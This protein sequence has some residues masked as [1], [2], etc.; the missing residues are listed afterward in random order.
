[1][2]TYPGREKLARDLGL[3]SHSTSTAP[4]L[5]DILRRSRHTP[6][7]PPSSAIKQL[8]FPESETLTS[9]R[10]LAQETDRTTPIIN[11]I[12]PLDVPSENRKVYDDPQLPPLHSGKLGYSRENDTTLLNSHTLQPVSNPAPLNTN[13]NSNLRLSSLKINSS[14][15]D[16][17]L[18]HPQSMSKNG[19]RSDKPGGLDVSDISVGT[20]HAQGVHA[21]LGETFANDS[22]LDMDKV[23]NS[24]ED[25]DKLANLAKVTADTHTVE[26]RRDELD[27]FF[28]T[29]F[30]SHEVKGEP[31]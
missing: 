19:T 7:P 1:M 11:S 21:E 5:V 30:P 12:H 25:L 8:K 14:I 24:T 27:D 4:L 2:E 31:R 13:E 22:T 23:L 17:T 15:P 29:T 28:D 10:F 3:D 6:S 9:D 16:E 26:A 20:L 18:K